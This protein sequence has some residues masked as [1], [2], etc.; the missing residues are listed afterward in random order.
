MEV[1]EVSERVESR[2]GFKGAGGQVDTYCFDMANQ[3][4][5]TG[6]ASCCCCWAAAGN[7]NSDGI[8]TIE[9]KRSKA[10]NTL[11]KKRRWNFIIRR[12]ATP[13]WPVPAGSPVFRA[14]V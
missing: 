8:K 4:V 10:K 3:D 1:L 9:R 7:Q 6:A 2:G 5:V 13:V 11:R 12:F 14:S